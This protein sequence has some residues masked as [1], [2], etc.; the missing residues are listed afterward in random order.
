MKRGQHIELEYKILLLL[1]LLFFSS[2]KY[3]EN[4]PN[5]IG[6]P[7]CLP[8]FIDNGEGKK[9]FTM[10]MPNAQNFVFFVCMGV[11]VCVHALKK[12][13]EITKHVLRGT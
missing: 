3:N 13:N 7:N 10:A 8:S 11:C 1:L 5:L 2:M 9:T 12:M 6:A 4:E